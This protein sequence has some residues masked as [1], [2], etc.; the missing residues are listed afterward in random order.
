MDKAEDKPKE[1]IVDKSP[2]RKGPSSEFMNPELKLSKRQQR[3]LGVKITRERSAA[4]KKRIEASTARLRAY[5]EGK[6]RERKQ[7]EAKVKEELGKRARVR[8]VDK[9]KRV[10]KRKVEV[11]VDSESDSSESSEVEYRAKKASRAAKAIAKLDEKM[12]RVVARAPV[13]PYTAAFMR[14]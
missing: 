6:S 1:E 9:P 8:I 7:A 5:N 12:S 4:E 10:K 3:I 11:S 13:N 2:E 14:M